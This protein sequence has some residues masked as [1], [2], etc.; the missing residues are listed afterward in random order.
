M[1]ERAYRLLLRAYPR[2]LRDAHGEEMLGLVRDRA[3]HGEPWWRLWPA[4]LSDTARGATS[5]RWEHLMTTHRSIVLGVIGAI[6]AL[7]AVS[8]GPRIALPVLIVAAMAIA[9]VFRWRPPVPDAPITSRTWQRWCGGGVVLI[10]VAV[11]AMAIV[12]REFTEIEWAM[13]FIAFVAGLFLTAT[14]LA[15]L[16]GSRRPTA[17]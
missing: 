3:G 7:A 9:F 12:D 17:T 4:L 2:S 11:A 14:G 6:A 8:D 10:A 5:T 15:L 16:A 13:V 1:T